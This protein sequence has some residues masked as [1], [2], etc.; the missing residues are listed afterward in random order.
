MSKP[1]EN[2]TSQPRLNQLRQ[3]D[4]R[5]SIGRHEYFQLMTLLLSNQTAS[6]EERIQINAIFDRVRLSHLQLVD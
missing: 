3:I 5:G 4:A 2:R 1:Q 6:Q